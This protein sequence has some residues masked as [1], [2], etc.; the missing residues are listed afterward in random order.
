MRNKFEEFTGGMKLSVFVVSAAV[1]FA[2][3]IATSE[4]SEWIQAGAVLIVA[5]MAVLFIRITGS[6]R[7]EETR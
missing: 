6:G 7:Q 3:Y 2:I 5:G 4:V 1:I